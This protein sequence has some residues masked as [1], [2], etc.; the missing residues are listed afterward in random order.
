M[1]KRGKSQMKN[2]KNTHLSQAKNNKDIY[3]L[4]YQELKKLHAG[5][6]ISRQGGKKLW[7]SPF[8]TAVVYYVIFAF[9][10]MKTVNDAIKVGIIPLKKDIFYRL[11]LLSRFKWHSFYYDLVIKFIEIKGL[12]LSKSYFIIDDSPFEKRGKKLGFIGKIYDH[13]THRHISGYTI[14]ALHMVVGEYSIPIDFLYSV[15]KKLQTISD[16]EL[17]QKFPSKKEIDKRIRSTYR[18]NKL[19]LMYELVSIA[20]SKGIN[21]PK[22]LFDSWY[23]CKESLKFFRGLHIEVIA[24]YKKGN[25]KFIHN[26]KEKDVSQIIKEQRHRFRKYFK[27]GF[28]GAKV[29]VFM[30]GVGYVTLIFTENVKSKKNKTRCFISTLH[31]SKYSVTELMREY[32]Y[33]WNIETSFKNLK[34]NYG[35]NSYHGTSEHALIAHTVLCYVRMMVVASI[36]NDFG[37]G[38]ISAFIK[39]G[40]QKIG[41]FLLRC[42][43]SF[44]YACEN[45][46]KSIGIVI[47]SVDKIGERLRNKIRLIASQFNLSVSNFLSRVCET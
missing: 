29:T 9:F 4:A 21:A 46:S 5:T 10:R 2:T 18:K 23:A 38:T 3:K 11:L 37:L 15:S 36:Q 35:F 19:H 41:H 17:N 43:D 45:F 12:D 16:K 7:G 13:V 39:K 20:I 1:G 33:R 31:G 32:S 8:L 27:D 6:S 44:D 34:Q 42:R 28:R 22:V 14:V 25:T 26:G 47:K 24:G 40:I 30:N